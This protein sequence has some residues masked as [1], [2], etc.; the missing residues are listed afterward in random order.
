[1]TQKYYT[2]RLLPVYVQAVK[3]GRKLGLGT[4]YLQEDGDPSHG[5]KKQGLA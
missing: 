3:D 4:W 5:I 1:M 2:E